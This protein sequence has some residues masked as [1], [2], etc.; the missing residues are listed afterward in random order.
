MV[1]ADAKNSPERV[2]W[3]SRVLCL[4]CVWPCSSGVTHPGKVGWHSLQGEGLYVTVDL[5]GE[6]ATVGGSQDAQGQL[7]RCHIIT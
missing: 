4:Q 3:T 2:V 5:H 7:S 1:T 6:T